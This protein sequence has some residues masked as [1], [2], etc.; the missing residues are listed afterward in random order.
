MPALG[1]SWAHACTNRIILHWEGDQRLAHLYKSP[2]LPTGTATYDVT[3][4]GVRG[5]KKKRPAQG[6]PP[7]E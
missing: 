7:A 6:P 1:E 2:R 5:I 4:D 3:A